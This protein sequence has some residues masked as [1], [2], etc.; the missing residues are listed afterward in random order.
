[1]GEGSGGRHG[2]ARTNGISRDARVGHRMSHSPTC[3]P[4]STLPNN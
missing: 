3:C 1:V 4:Y 2:A